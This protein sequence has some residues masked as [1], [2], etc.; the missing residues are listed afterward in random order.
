M[1]AKMAPSLSIHKLVCVACVACLVSLGITCEAAKAQ[2]GSLP[3]AFEGSVLMVDGRVDP[4]NVKVVLTSRSG[5]E[6]SRS[7]YLKVPL[8]FYKNFRK[9]GGSAARGSGGSRREVRPQGE[10][11]FRFEDL[12]LPADS[13]HTLDVF[14]IGLVFPQYR[15]EV[16]SESE[17]TISL[18]QDPNKV[19]R[20][21]L[22][23]K[24][25]G[26]IDYFDRSKG[27]SIQSLLK[28]PMYLIMGVTALAALF[29]PKMLDKDALEEMQ[30]EMGKLEEQRSTGQSS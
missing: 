6:G 12:D 3:N 26:A 16:G 19:F 21:P 11:K 10:F 17:I 1:I 2:E 22:K 28:N 30:R 25:V 5:H 8:S 4:G 14:A 29:L 9:E 18:N 23:V 15:V 27:F 20:Y 7:T 13:V 24:P